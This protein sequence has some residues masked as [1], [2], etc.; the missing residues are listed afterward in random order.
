MIPRNKAY[1]TILALV[2]AAAFVTVLIPHASV[3]CACREADTPREAAPPPACCGSCAAEMPSAPCGLE[4]VK[5]FH[6]DSS[7]N[8]GNCKH[9]ELTA[10]GSQ[11]FIPE[12]TDLA[13][14]EDVRPL[15]DVAVVDG[16]Q[17]QE[18]ASLIELGEENRF[19]LQSAALLSSSVLRC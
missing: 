4:S 11:P 5:T 14:R 19:T 2:A 8:C 15:P 6:Y 12:T 18:T 17:G 3:M 13:H 1:R 16:W 7:C 10:P 9:V